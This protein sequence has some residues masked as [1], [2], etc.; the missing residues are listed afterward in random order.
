MTEKEKSIPKCRRIL[1]LEKKHEGRTDSVLGGLGKSEH[2]FVM[3]GRG[4][5]GM[6]LGDRFWWEWST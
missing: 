5:G 2:T 4:G 1:Y 3:G 6:E